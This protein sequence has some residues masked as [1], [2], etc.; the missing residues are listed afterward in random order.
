MIENEWK[1]IMNNSG[2][3]SETCDVTIRTK[4]GAVWDCRFLKPSCRFI[5]F[6]TIIDDVIEWKYRD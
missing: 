3:P 1:K 6:T 4:Y 2:Y 5:T